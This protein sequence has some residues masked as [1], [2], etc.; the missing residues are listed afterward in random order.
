MIP[1]IPTL[2]LAIVS[3]LSSAFVILRTI[4]PILYPLAVRAFPCPCLRVADLFLRA[5]ARKHPHPVCE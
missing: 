2:T 4:T 3:F 5:I 1:L